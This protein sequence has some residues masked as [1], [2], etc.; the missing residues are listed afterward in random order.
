ME[1][2]SHAVVCDFSKRGKWRFRHDRAEL[3]PFLQGLQ[4]L[5]RPHRLAHPVNTARVCHRREEINPLV[6]VSSFEQP[7][8]REFSPTQ[9]MRPGV[10]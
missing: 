4:Q 6:N 8:G 2:L 9:P 5:S 7:I 10:G 3:S 1:G